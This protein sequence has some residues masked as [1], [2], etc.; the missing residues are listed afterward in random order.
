MNPWICSWC[1]TVQKILLENPLEALYCW[2]VLWF[3]I[4]CYGYVALGIFFIPNRMYKYYNISLPLGLWF[5]EIS[6]TLFFCFSHGIRA[7]LGPLGF[8]FSYKAPTRRSDCGASL[9]RDWTDLP[10]S[11]PTSS[12]W[13][14]TNPISIARIGVQSSTV[15]YQEGW[16]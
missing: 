15:P 2:L 13:E 1:P 14:Q 8:V 5:I 3:W 6:P 10:P 9:V 4:L 7:H 12:F 16:D 11:P